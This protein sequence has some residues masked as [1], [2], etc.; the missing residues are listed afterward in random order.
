MQGLAAERTWIWRSDTPEGVELL[1]GTNDGR[2]C[3]MLHESYALCIVPHGGNRK[4]DLTRWK[5][6]NREYIYRPG[7]IGVEEPGE[8]HTCLRVYSP[9]RYC[10]MRIQ[11]DLLEQSARELGVPHVHFPVPLTGRRDLYEAFAS[12]YRSAARSATVLERQVH[13]TEFI[14]RLLTESRDPE[15]SGPA[16]VP[17]RAVERAREYLAEHYAEAVGIEELSRV[18]GMSRF[19]LSR[20]FAAAYGLSPHAYQN[21]LRLRSVR[22]SLRNGWRLDAIEAGFFD[23]SHMIRHFRDSM[24]LTPGEFASPLPVPLP[25][26]D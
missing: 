6:R 25:P 26:L 10:M 15:S 8:V 4:T 2:R 3:R 21:Q 11:P 9:I 23:Q 13:L 5:Y 16:R 18:A 24:G 1:L 19:H 7:A 12:F 14:R 17:H 20:I 22:A